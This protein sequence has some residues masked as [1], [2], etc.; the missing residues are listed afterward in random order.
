MLIL[1][2][3]ELRNDLNMGE[4]ERYKEIRNRVNVMNKENEEDI[5]GRSSREK[6][7]TIDTVD[8]KKYGKS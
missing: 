3:I 1:I 7:N 2:T 6:L 5:F 8:R 4:Q